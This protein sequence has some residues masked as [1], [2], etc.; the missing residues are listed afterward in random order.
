MKPPVV[1]P[2]ALALFMAVTV[3]SFA[4]AAARAP[5]SFAAVELGT[6]LATWRSLK[7]PGAISDHVQK[8]CASDRKGQN[9]DLRPTDVPEDAVVCGYV[10]AYGTLRLPVTFPWGHGYGMDRLRYV[11]RDG[12]LTEIRADIDNDGFNALMADFKANWGTPS[13][14]VRDT[15]NTEIGPEPRVRVTWS[16]PDGQVSIVDPAG[17]GKLE[18]RLSAAGAAPSPKSAH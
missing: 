7:P 12:K 18:V 13:R 15:A 4:R 11:F 2:I 17:P 10:D 8:V 16:L 6:P 14:L 3:P 9:A 1:P 5:I